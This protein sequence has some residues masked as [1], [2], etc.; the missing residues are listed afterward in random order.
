MAEPTSTIAPSLVVS[1]PPAAVAFYR[2]AF[3]AEVLHEVPG[4]GV[5][6]LAVEGAPFWLSEPGAALRRG[7]PE[8]LGGWSVWMILTV[9]D[10][11]ALWHA[12]VG[13]GATPEAE[14]EQAHGW[15]LGRVVDPFGHR[16]EI[17]RPLP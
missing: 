10:P 4:G 3:G 15:R 17:G 1:D 8:Q 7:T 14:M 5:V 13:A 16:W 11:D 9:T 6:Q 12:A 2:K